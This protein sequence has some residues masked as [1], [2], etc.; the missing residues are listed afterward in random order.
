MKKGRRGPL[1]GGL[2]SELSAAAHQLARFR[3]SSNQ[4]SKRRMQNTPPNQLRQRSQWVVWKLLADGRKMPI[5]PHTGRAAKTDDP[6][7]WGAYDFAAAKQASWGYT[8]VG[9]VFSP[10]DAYC[11]I[12]FDDCRDPRSGRIAQWAAIAIHNVASYSEVSPSGRGVK[13]WAVGSLPTSQTGGQR[14]R[15]NGGAVELYDCRR[16]FAYTGRHLTGT[17]GTVEPAQEAIDTIWHWID[18]PKRHAA[19]AAEP[20]GLPPESRAVIDRALNYAMAVPGA[21]SG[22]RGHDKTLWLCCRLLHGFGLSIDK[23]WP[24]LV[25]WNETCQP[26]WSGRDLWRKLEQADLQEDRKGRKRG[27]LR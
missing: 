1:P 16:Y 18:E 2:V 9:F 14:K 24:I 20:R 23:A 10:D 19:A 27:Y 6:T 26:P 22:Q 5:D 15:K 13:V 21:V 3:S 11:G 25:Q 7:T 12:D 17:P 8:G 4:I